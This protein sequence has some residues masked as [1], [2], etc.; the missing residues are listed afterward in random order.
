MRFIKILLLSL[1]IS[2]SAFAGTSYDPSNNL[3]SARQLGMGGVSVAYSDDANGVFSNP[4]GL[5]EVVFPQLSGSSRTT[6]MDEVQYSL[7]AWA[8][9]TDWGVFGFGFVG[10]NTSGSYPTTLDPVTGR[11]T[12]DTSRETS[13]YSNSTLAISYSK[14]IN[15]QFS[16]GGAYKIFN[17]HL[18]GGTYS[19]ASASGIDLSASFQPFDWLTAGV[20]LQNLAEGSLKWTGGTSDTIGGFYKFGLKLNLLGS[21]YKALRSHSQGLTVGFDLDLPHNTISGSNYHLGLEYSP[22]SKLFI[23]T[24]ISQNGLA[25]GVGLE[26]SGF[27][28]DYAYS[29]NPNLPGELPHYFTLSYVGERS[30]S[31]TQKLKRKEAVFVFTGPRDRSI[32]SSYEVTLSFEAYAKRT[33][34]QTTVWTVTSLS[35]TQE[36]HEVFKDESLATLSLNG[37]LLPENRHNFEEKAFL[38]AGR[39]V[40]RLFGYTAPEQLPDRKVMDAIP[41]SAEVRILHFTPFHDTPMDFW[42]IEPIAL[43]STLGLTAGYP[44]DT[45]KPDKG[46]T[47]AELVTLLV[48]TMA[49]TLEPGWEFTSFTDVPYGHWAAKHVGYSTHKKL[50]TGY[51]DSTFKPKKVLTRAEGVA[52]F[53]R[54]AGISEEVILIS[55]EAMLPFPDLKPNF[56]ANKYIVPAYHAGLLKYLAGKEF[57]PSAPFTRAEACEILYQTPSVKKLVDEWW[58]TGI[59]PT[60]TLQPL[61]ATSE[62]R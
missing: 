38:H 10:E 49:A 51:P 44:D 4:A 16:I 9:P 42:A 40:L 36:T 17:Q 56:W 35:S 28:F 5:T 22:L 32:T 11:I 21:S 62:S 46:I 25:F 18:S 41:V 24:G 61:P 31:F 20:N 29:S 37:K 53:A 1:V 34:D 15:R 12:I 48:R 30:A 8:M 55:A 58:N 3:F 50:V 57:K 43:C 14:K 60:Q 19:D 59:V 26:N 6:L 45:F 33:I 13:S 47:R 2:H 52:I 23:R 39:N 7:A 27:R 54:Y